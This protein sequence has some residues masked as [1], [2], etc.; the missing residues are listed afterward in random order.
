MSTSHKSAEDDAAAQEFTDTV[1]G[2]VRKYQTANG[3]SDLGLIANYTSSGKHAPA[4]V[5]GDSYDRLR[6]VKVG[7]NNLVPVLPMSMADVVPSSRV[8]A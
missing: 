4:T 2:I 5:W 3:G 7:T 8:V 6:E 1:T